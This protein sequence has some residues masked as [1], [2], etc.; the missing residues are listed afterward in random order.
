MTEQSPRSS[1]IL[2]LLDEI[3]RMEDTVFYLQNRIL[4]KRVAVGELLNGVEPGEATN[5][6]LASTAET[7]PVAETELTRIPRINVS[8]RCR[9]YFA[10]LNGN[11]FW[12]KHVADFVIQAE[13]H[14]DIRGVKRAVYQTVSFAL[15][16]G[17][18]KR[19]PGGFTKA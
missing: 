15:K 7:P 3:C 5:P 4:K 14:A 8:Q 12:Y 1:V 10:T 11:V 6:I 16:K 13:P 9:D 17:Q 2:E 18:I 19:C